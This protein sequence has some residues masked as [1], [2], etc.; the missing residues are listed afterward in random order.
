M[1]E[2]KKKENYKLELQKICTR[3]WTLE[4]ETSEKDNEEL[5]MV[6][7]EICLW[8]MTMSKEY[9]KRTLNYQKYLIK[10]KANKVAKNIGDSKILL[11][12]KTKIYIKM[13]YTVHK[14]HENVLFVVTL[15]GRT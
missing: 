11:N 6:N 14:T 3:N 10:H 4:F 2:I 15:Q 1:K 9:E 8:N 5:C 12:I 13:T 7:N